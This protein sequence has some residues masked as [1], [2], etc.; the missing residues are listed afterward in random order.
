MKM[1]SCNF[2]LS[3]NPKWFPTKVNFSDW[4]TEPISKMWQNY[5]QYMCKLRDCICTTTPW[6][7]GGQRQESETPA[8]SDRDRAKTG[9]THTPA[10]TQQCY[11]TNL[12]PHPYKDGEI[13]S[14]LDPKEKYF[15][16]INSFSSVNSLCLQSEESESWMWSRTVV[17]DSLRPYGL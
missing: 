14:W 6:S 12:F 17:S 9:P 4:Y 7:Q 11:I 15:H 2:Y 3:W 5:A 13:P 16:I 10:L 1:F 8:L